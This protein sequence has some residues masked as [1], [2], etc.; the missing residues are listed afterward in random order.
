MR[1]GFGIAGLVIV[2]FAM[3]AFFPIN[4]LLSAVESFAQLWRRL[5]ATTS[6]P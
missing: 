1:Q 3:I 2:F 5:P 4:L 6:S